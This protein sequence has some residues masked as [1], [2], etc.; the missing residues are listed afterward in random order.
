MTIITSRTKENGKINIDPNKCNLC[1]LCVEICPDDSLIIENEMLT[2]NPNPFFGCLACGHCV[3][4]CP[5]DAIIVTGR[6]VTENDYVKLPKSDSKMGFDSLYPLLFSRRSIRHF[7]ENEVERE[8][9]DKILD[10]VTTAPMGIPPSDVKVIVLAGRDKVRE[11]GIDF[12]KEL[13]K[14]N[15]MMPFMIK[16]M[17]PFISKEQKDAFNSFIIPLMKGLSDGYDKGHDYLLYD[18]PLAIYFYCPVFSDSADAI[19]AATYATIAAESLGIGSCMIGTVAPVIQRASKQFKTKYGIE[20]KTSSGIMVIFGYPKFRFQ[21]G[22]K[23]SLAEIAW[24]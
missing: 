17:W 12:S 23:R 14:V 10:A 8:K 2:V 18:A 11:F 15:K 5:K 13:K 22:V 9:I 16:L 3:A 1:R 7:K 6:T 4:I 19:I 24:K 21:K 20:K